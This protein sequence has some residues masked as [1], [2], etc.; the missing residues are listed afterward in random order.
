[1]KFPVEHCSD[2][3]ATVAEDMPGHPALGSTFHLKIN[4]NRLEIQ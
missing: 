4:E 3:Q 1:M 2:F